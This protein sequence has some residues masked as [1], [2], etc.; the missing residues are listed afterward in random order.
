MALVVCITLQSQ[1]AATVFGQA[2]V[3]LEK[4][5]TPQQV[6]AQVQQQAGILPA[7]KM[8]RCISAYMHIWL[9][10]FDE[11]EI[12]KTEMLRLLNTLEGVQVAQVNHVIAERIVPND[13]FFGQQWHH[14]QSGDHDIDTD[15]AW[16]ITTGGVTALGDEIV[17]CVVEPGGAKWNQADINANHWIN[18]NEIPNNN[19]DD[20]EN[21]YIDD[22]D[23]WNTTADSDG[24]AEGGHGT[25]V[26]S[27]IGA[28][29]DNNTGIAGVNWD[30]KIMQV[31]MGGI[32]E[33][34]VIEAYEYPLMMRKLYNE[35]NGQKGAFVVAT[36]SSWGT[37]GGQPD[38]A[39]LWCAMYDSLGAYG[40]LSCGATANN[41][42]NI[43]VVGDLPTACPSE[44]MVSVTAT[45]NDDVR[46]FSGYG[47]TQIDLG[48]PGEDVYLANN[49]SYGATS[50]TSFASP[51]VAGAIALLYSAPCTSFM[52]IVAASPADG[53]T[54]A[55][56][57]IY[58]GVDAVAN[59]S[60][61]C[62]TGGRLN[63]NNSIN[64]ML[65]DC[66]GGSCVAPFAVTILQVPG[67]LNYTISWL[68]TGESSGFALRYRLSGEDVWTELS[69]LTEQTL[70]LQDLLACY[71]YEVQLLSYCG[72]G[73]SDWG[74]TL[75]FDTEGCCV[76]PTIYSE[77]S[78]T[79]T[80]A[81]V[82]WND[83]FAAEGYTLTYQ[84]AGGV[85]ITIENVAT[86]QYTLTDLLPCTA[87]SITVFSTCIGLE[88]TPVTFD[89]NTSGCGDCQDL[90]YC[91]IASNSASEFIENVTLG[92]INYTSGDDD[93]YLLVEG[94]TTIL[95]KDQQYTVYCTPGFDGFA[96]SE[97]FKVWI[98][99]N[100]NGE[101]E[102]A[103]ELVFDSGTGTTT[104][105]SGDFTVPS[106]VQDGVVRMRVGMSYVGSFGGGE[107]P[108]ACGENEYGETEDYCVTLEETVGLTELGNKTLSIYPNPAQDALTITN[109]N[110]QLGEKGIA[111]IIDSRGVLVASSVFSNGG[112]IDVSHLAAG[113]YI[114]QVE[115]NQT[116]RFIK[117]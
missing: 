92:D 84:P 25:Q 43:D 117:K 91:A 44:Y 59:L 78:V 76:N 58:S 109:P 81:T 27:M 16:D 104:E 35:T 49:T 45:N 29:G 6:Q 83:V 115:E 10:S 19:I 24:I 116:T 12:A 17:V 57:F 68:A 54:M 98:D 79:D 105:V 106:W 60:D 7:F 95:V 51:C 15:L 31:D 40:I 70:V 107:P 114:V 73:D 93:G 14:V 42:V 33:A 85:A 94:E 48:A 97:Y 34:G 82:Q 74:N 96:Y 32:S 55:R 56:D 36:N 110:V 75:S 89:F 80:E 90:A 88:P 103:T 50:G 112:S 72:K 67:T 5:A 22:V 2:L 62:V 9:F 63:I 111:N 52:Q 37:D 113:L 101:F 26:S 99:Y 64:L 20:D 108:I 8:E 61:E 87:Y 1:Q 23:G 13:P 18:V 30:V 47:Q 53:A 71:T 102:D 21:G 38:D 3:Q 69:G 100:S 65:N 41:N 11:N 4:T 77:V 66:S 46:T 28:K 39:P 86:N